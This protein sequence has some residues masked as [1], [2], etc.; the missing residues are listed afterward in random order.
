MTYFFQTVLEKIINIFQSPLIDS[1]L[2]L[3]P[4]QIS[5]DIENYK[6]DNKNCKF[7]QNFEHAFSVLVK[8][9]IPDSVSRPPLSEKEVKHVKEYLIDFCYAIF[10]KEKMELPPSQIQFLNSERDKQFFSVQKKW[11]DAME[12]ANSIH[13]NNNNNNNNNNPFLKNYSRLLDLVSLE[14]NTKKLHFVSELCQNADDNQYF[15]NDPSPPH[16]E[17]RVDSKGIL[18]RNNEIGFTRKNLKSICSSGISSKNFFGSSSIGE[19]GIGFKS[20]FAVTDTPFIV[21][22]GTLP[23]AKKHKSTE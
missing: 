11:K 18:V 2:L 22:N 12:D 4:K 10:S 13:N 6:L 7:I 1:F 15:P 8:N 5:Q 14:L 17:F 23:N 9:K 20:V 19:K 21:S 16:I 3:L